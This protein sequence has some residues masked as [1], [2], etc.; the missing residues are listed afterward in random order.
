MD[1]CLLHEDML[2]MVFEYCNDHDKCFWTATAVMNNHPIAPLL[3]RMCA[4]SALNPSVEPF[5]RFWADDGMLRIIQEANVESIANGISL[6][7]V[8]FICTHTVHE[9]TCKYKGCT[10]HA[11]ILHCEMERVFV[12]LNAAHCMYTENMLHKVCDL[13][14][15]RRSLGSRVYIQ[16]H[17]LTICPLKMQ[18]C[19][20]EDCLCRQT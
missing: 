16:R 12:A 17:F 14:F 19:V 13:F 8:M 5:N 7:D 4:Q 9:G 20:V 2:R 1:V 3:L 6:A 15:P 10:D 18:F 11:S